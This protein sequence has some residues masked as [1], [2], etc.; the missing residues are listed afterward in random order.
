MAAEKFGLWLVGA[1]GGV[2]ATVATGL[3]ALARGDTADTGLV[4]QLPCF[5][6]SDLRPLD[7]WVVGGHEV[8]SGS[9]VESVQR[10]EAQ[11]GAIPPGS[12][13][14]YADELAKIDR[15]IRPGVLFRSGPAIDSLADSD[16]AVVADSPRAAVDRIAADLREFAQES[17]LKR[18]VVVLLH[19]TEPPTDES[20]LPPSWEAM[21]E[22][23]ASDT[24][25]QLRASSLYAIAALECGMPVVNFTPAVGPCCT[26]IDQLARSRGVPYAGSDG[27]PEKLCSSRFWLR[28]SPRGVWR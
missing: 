16:F 18:V 25:C 7:A 15:R 26:A 12:A 28:C 4:T 19:S 2:A 20:A 27:K 17:G 13:A 6:E 11:Q 3:A 8:R 24:E 21:N 5:G 1:R 23:L 14:R 22:S 10:L 9:L